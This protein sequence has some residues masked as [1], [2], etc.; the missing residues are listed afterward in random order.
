MMKF[1]LLQPID[2]PVWNKGIILLA[3]FTLQFEMIS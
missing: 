2:S 3:V 1:P